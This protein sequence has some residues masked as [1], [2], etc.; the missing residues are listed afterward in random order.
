MKKNVLLGFG[1]LL[2]LGLA[3][4]N[5]KPAATPANASAQGGV[6]GNLVVWMDNDPWANAVIARFNQKYPDV[7]VSYQNVGNVD[8]RGK[9]SLDG[10]AGIGPDVFLMPHD[11]IGLAVA[12][13][14]CEPFDA[15]PQAKYVAAMLESS[16]Q[17]CTS[18]GKLFAVPIST[19]NIAFFYNKDLL[20]DTPVPQSFEEV[21]AFAQKYNVPAQNKWALRWQVDDAYLNYFFLTAF[22][23]RVF[24]PNMNDYHNPGFDSPE[25]TKGVDYFRSLR[26]IYNVNVSDAD[27]SGTVEVFQNGDVPFTITGPWAIADAK[28]N[29]VNFGITKLP[30]IAGN[31]P[32][33]FSGNIIAAVSSY[34]KNFD[35]AF[36]FVDFLAS[37]EGQTIQFE[38]TGK[39][40]T[41]KDAS[42]VGGISDDPYLMGVAEQSPYAD[43]MPIIPE[44]N[45]MWDALKN[46]FTFTWDNTLTTAQAQAKSMET[47]DTALQLAGKK[48]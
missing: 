24:G 12:D 17:T 26:S 5:K 38:Q 15:E 28:K 23:M 31:Q 46:L 33:C 39:L 25:V 37:P 10:P 27:W 1:V 41:L 16:I 48:R 18:N 21:V 32:H 42:L 44:V 13:G 40:T 2:V 14:L 47:Y 29:G 19:E 3:A 4:C 7:K 34:A 20:G 9:V 30:T 6:S 45:Q 11:H 22:G 8:T 35:A 36:A 43:P